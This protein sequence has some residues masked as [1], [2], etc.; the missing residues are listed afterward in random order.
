MN[1][2]ALIGL[3]D[4]AT[5]LLALGVLYDVVLPR[6]RLQTPRVK[7]LLGLVL[8]TIGAA[9]MLHAWV[10]S[11]DVVFDTRSILISVTALFFGPMPTTVAAAII[12]VFRLYLGGA[13]AVTGV[14]VIATSAGLGLAWR[15]LRRRQS[16]PLRWWELYV[17]GVVVHIAMLL[18]MLMLGWSAAAKVL[19]HISLPVMIIYPVATVLFGGLLVHQQTRRQTQEALRR[20]RDLLNRIT[21][22]G[23]AGILVVD[24]T[25]QITFVNPFAEQLLGMTGDEIRQRNYNAPEWK[26]T[27]FEG[28]AIP[29]DQL[30]FSRVMAADEP[31]FDVQH[32]IENPN[33]RRILLSINA[34]PLHDAFGQVE[35]VVATLQDIT[36]RVRA[37]QDRDRIE[38][39]LRQAQKM[40]AVGRLA[41]GVAHDFNNMLTVILGY[42]D[43]M[44]RH[45]APQDPLSQAVHEIRSA[46]QRSADLTRQLLAFSRKQIVKLA[47]VNLNEQV[48]G[49]QKL[50]ARLIGEDIK[51]LFMPA[52]DL[53]N[54]RI[55]PSQV[56]QILANLAANARDAIANAGTI[57]IETANVTLDETYSRRSLYVAPGDYV[58]LA[59]TDT[60][61][62]MD[63]ATLEHIFEPFFTT[64]GDGTGLGLSTVYGI[65]KQNGGVIHAYSEPGLGTS[66]KIYLP[67]FCGRIANSGPE[68][69]NACLDGHEVVLIVEDEEQI[70]K[71]AKAVLEQHG[72]TVLTATTPGQACTM[73]EEHAGAIDLLLTDVVLPGMNGKQLHA[74]MEQIKPGIKVLFMSGYTANV[75][76][77]R[78]VLEEGIDF[79]QKP[80]SLDV[81]ARKVRAVLDDRA[82]ERGARAE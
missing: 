4:N 53:W 22:T 66:F 34:A 30:P 80:F 45:L 56:D 52:A 38:A 67:R 48:A 9:V 23:P 31:V 74:R 46:A 39:E 11:S 42:A 57:T 60:G 8:G 3:V 2:S 24:R 21:Q 6:Q 68:E 5:L 47:A 63:A 58:M 79:L 32:A 75:I 76:V 41:G 29:E 20:E 59:F 72:Y 44:R 62:G 12:S 35:G 73:A 51:I 13:G 54:I 33:G 50:L 55:D 37:E 77:H 40:E 71:I 78:G 25:G 1:G 70:L 27:D 64:K 36:E 19:S 17:F 18:C 61:A 16:Q 26:A 15:H 10:F 81:L 28:N 43:S 7:A 14:L 69:T 82:E 49:Q 65:V